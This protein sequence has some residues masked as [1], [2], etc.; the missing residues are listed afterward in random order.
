MFV[1]ALGA[2]STYVTG[3]KADIT[4]GNTSGIATV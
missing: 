3:V 4:Y 2:G 1:L